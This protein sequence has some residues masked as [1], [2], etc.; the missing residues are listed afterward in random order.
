MWGPKET[1]VARKAKV[2]TVGRDDRAAAPAREVLQLEEVLGQDRA[3]A[4]LRAAVG[5]GR[6]HHAWI[7]HGP[8]GVGKFTTALAFGAMLIDPEVAPDLAGVLRADPES[9]AQRLVRAGT[10]PDLHVVTKE[11]AAVSEDATIRDR[12]QSNIPKAVLREFLLEP[13]AKTRVMTGASAAGK[14]FIVD[15]AELIDAVGQNSLLKMLEEPPAGSVIILATS[16]EERLLPTIRSRCQ[17]VAF[18]PLD[19]ASMER[20]LARRAAELAPEQRAWLL[21]F[22]GGS[23]G[24]AAMVLENDLFAWKDALEPALA[25]IDG[26]QF[27]IEM[28]ATLADLIDERAA[29]WVKR[30]PDASKDAANKAWARRMLGFLAEHFRAQLGDPGRGARAAASIHSIARAEEQLGANVNLALVMENLAAQLSLGGNASVVE[31]AA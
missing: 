29:A 24:A 1:R 28:G 8:M 4:Q 22:A 27:P 10:H 3:I 2:Q 9:R 21:R 31:G 13:A 18:G 15:E 17:R 30:H 14:V 19:A 26:G 6:V 16:S 5:S 23:P 25:K 11:L 7:F 12:K 20:W